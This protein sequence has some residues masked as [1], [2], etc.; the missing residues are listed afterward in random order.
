MTKE[1]LIDFLLQNTLGSR[2]IIEITGHL[3]TGKGNLTN[4]IREVIS[5]AKKIS[6]ADSLKDFVK[7]N[8]GIEKFRV[9]KRIPL[10]QTKCLV[11]PNCSKTLYSQPTHTFI[12][13]QFPPHQIY[14]CCNGLME[15]SL[16]LSNR[17]LSWYCVP[18][19]SDGD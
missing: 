1:K 6:F 18:N 17:V 11:S 19:Q 2:V 3:R 12:I 8:L 15:L 5:T 7:E 10:E 9:V 16:H 13:L 4:Q 14:L